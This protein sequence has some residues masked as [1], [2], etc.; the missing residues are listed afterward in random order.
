[1]SYLTTQIKYMRVN[2]ILIVILV[3]PT[4]L[5]AAYSGW[6]STAYIEHG[7]ASTVDFQTNTQGTMAFWLIEAGTAGTQRVLMS[8]RTAGFAGGQLNID[9]SDRMAGSRH[10]SGGG[11]Q[12]ASAVAALS[13]FPVYAQNK[14][15]FVVWSWDNSTGGNNKIWMGDSSTPAAEPSSY[16]TQQAG[17]GTPVDESAINI[18]IASNT[19][20]AGAQWVGKI[21]SFYMF[22]KVLSRGEIIQLQF[23]GFIP[24]WSNMVVNTQYGWHASASQVDFSGKRNH[25]TITG[26][27]TRGSHVPIR[28]PFGR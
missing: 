9:S 15:L 4:S 7:S 6:S 18:R 21:A 20:T 8:K 2:I 12:H 27:L 1:M 3:F 24:A 26:T 10:F 16:V 22:N 14:W 11:S 23:F 19:P 25:G 17:I 28:S 13:S 5:H